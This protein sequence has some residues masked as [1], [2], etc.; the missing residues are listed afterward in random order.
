MPDSGHAIN[1]QNL[2]KARDIAVAWGPT[3]YNPSHPDLKILSLTSQITA[4]E[5]ALDAVQTAETPWR[6]A[7]SAAEDAFAGLSSLVR[8]VERSAKASGLAPS[9]L[10]DLAAPARKVKGQRATPKKPVDNGD[11]TTPPADGGGTDGGG[12]PGGAGTGSASQMSRQQRIEHFDEMIGL[13][14]SQAGYAPNETELTVAEL[15]AQS[16]ALQT[17][18]DDV[19]AKLAPLNEKRN[20]RNSVLYADGT[21]VVNTGRLFK[22]Y[23]QS[24]FGLKSPEWNQVKNLKFT[25]KTG[26]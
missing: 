24:A 6:N 25:D 2:K 11:G 18:V 16:T 8:R 17:L 3:K 1:V 23:V 7:T 21:N 20:Q 15:Q 9:F 13:L 22:A 19:S 10:E 26:S 12:T 14:Q 4:A 5:A